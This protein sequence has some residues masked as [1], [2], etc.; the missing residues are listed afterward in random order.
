MFI[1]LIFS[2][3]CFFLLSSWRL[4][5]LKVCS[6]PAGFSFGFSKWSS[7]KPKIDPR[8]FTYWSGLFDCHDKNWVPAHGRG[9][10]DRRG[11]YQDT[12]VVLRI[13][14]QQLSLRKVE[15]GKCGNF[16]VWTQIFLSLNSFS[17][18]TSIFFI[19]REVPTENSWSH[20]GFIP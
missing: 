5:V 6:Q 12:G 10:K 1:L 14:A 7:G 2:L 18:W 8:Q 19:S 3:S 4:V 13:E 9:E 16:R 20:H 15:L 11:D 17:P